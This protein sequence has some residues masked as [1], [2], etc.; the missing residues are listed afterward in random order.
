[1]K[2]KPYVSV[3]LPVYNGELYVAQA[4]DSIL[5]QSYTNFELIII[6]DY[7]T[8]STLDIVEKFRIIDNRIIVIK[9]RKNVGPTPVLN[10]GLKHVR[11]KY[12]IRM[13]QDDWSYPERFMMQ[14]DL[15][16]KNQDVVV[17]GSYVE[18][19]DANLNVKQLRK[20]QLSDENIR[21]RLFRYSPFAHSVTIWKSD[22]LVREKY[23]ENIIMGQDYELYFR[24]GLYGKFMNIDR[25][26]LKLR[27]H[28]DSI[29]STMNDLQS[30]E[31]IQIRRRAVSKYGY[32]MTFFDILYTNLQELCISIIPIRMRFALFN[33][34][35]RFRFY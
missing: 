29:S 11:G 9:N 30:E 23:N 17:S 22:V 35:R 24:V 5:D 8:D 18:I 1:M 2:F 34:L 26:L 13:D 14:V 21:K 6:D 15:M 4:I 20:Y 27:M 28:E 16:E 32:K 3:L 12:V 7:S 10:I 31:T 33:F 19:C 25:P